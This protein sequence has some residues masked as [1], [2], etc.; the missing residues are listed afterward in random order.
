VLEEEVPTCRKLLMHQADAKPNVLLRLLQLLG[1]L[2]MPFWALRRLAEVLKVAEFSARRGANDQE[3]SS[4]P[5]QG[6]RA[7]LFMFITEVPSR[8]EVQTFTWFEPVL[9]ANLCHSRRRVH[10]HDVDPAKN[11]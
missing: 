1:E 3:W 10:F 11:R 9:A 6:A 8:L 7:P 5:N 4:G 2:G